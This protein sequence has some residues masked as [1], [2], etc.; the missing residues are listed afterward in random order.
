M[1]ETRT[2]LITGASSGIGKA[3]AEKFASKNFNLIITYNQNA[4]GGEMTKKNCIKKGAASAELFRLNLSDGKSIAD[5]T[6]E[7]K[8]KKFDILINNAAYL[9]IGDILAMSDRDI[10]EMIN[11]NLSGTIKLTRNLLP[12]VEEV[13]INIGSYLSFQP[14]GRFAVYSASKYGLRGFTK[15]LAL[16]VKN[17][18]IYLFN[19]PVTA[20]RMASGGIEPAFVADLIY[21][22]ADKQIRLKSGSEINYN[23]Y[24]YGPVLAPAVHIYKKIRQFKQL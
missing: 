11:T 4:E 16:N 14:K 22:V 12:Q 18:K 10:D 19:P 20:T 1:S 15:S 6:A 8:N 21:K 7:I 24:K 13:I 9:A 17:K 3:T 5:F 2:V 23:D